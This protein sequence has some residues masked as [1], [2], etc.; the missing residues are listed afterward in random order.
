MSLFV[1]GA[2]LPSQF[3]MPV[4]AAAEKTLGELAS[5]AS[6]LAA[7]SG[8]RLL[9]C[10]ALVP[11]PRDPRGVRHSLPCVLALCTAAVL[12]GNASFEDVAAWAHRAPQEVLAACGAR[13]DGLGIYAGPHPDTT[14]RVFRKLGAHALASHA[15]AYLALRAQP[16]P[17]MFPLAGPALLPALAVD[18]KAVRGAAGDDGRIPYL[19]AAATHGTGAVLAERLIGPKTNEVPEFGPLLLELNAYYPLAGHVITAD[20]GHTVKAHAA[21]ICEKLLAHYVFTVKLNTPKLWEELDALDWADVPRLVT[22]ERGHGRWERRTIQVMNVPERIAK[23][24]PHARQA[25][26]VERYVTRTVRVR[27]GKRWVRK[28][29]RSAIAV[30]IITSLDAREASPEHIAGY[31]RRH[32]TIE[33]KVHWVR[34]VTFREDSSLVRTGPSPRIMVTLR[35]LAIGLIRQA[36]YTKIAATIRKIKYDTGLLLTILGLKNPS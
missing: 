14:E 26:L 17:A 22:E 13:R 34:D 2:P 20:A 12:N 19:L 29:A 30:F 3:R 5:R 16:G 27:K 33:N 36:G 9:A 11:D 35:N 1:P 31:V 28:Q 8:G 4:S 23:R 6:A 15:G 32:W 24:F 10:F 25:A 7:A 21:L 18:G